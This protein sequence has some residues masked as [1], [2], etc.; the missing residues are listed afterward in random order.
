MV[1]DVNTRNEAMELGLASDDVIQALTKALVGKIRIVRV[2]AASA[3]ATWAA[4]RRK[5]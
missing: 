4:D 2:R 1:V 5:L 3:L